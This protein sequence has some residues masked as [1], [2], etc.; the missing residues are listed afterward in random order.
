MVNKNNS[1]S[2]YWANYILR[3]GRR[4]FFICSIHWCSQNQKQNQPGFGAETRTILDICSIK[5]L[6]GRNSVFKTWW[7]LRGGLQDGLWEWCQAH[8]RTGLPGQLQLYGSC[9]QY[10][11]SSALI[12]IS[13]HLYLPTQN[14]QSS[15]KIASATFMLSK[16]QRSVLNLEWVI[17]SSIQ[18]FSCKEEKLFF[19]F[20]A[21]S[22]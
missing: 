19:S 13:L 11:Q 18:N 17:F 12:R 14:S 10:P 9:L 8:S 1:I 15:W 7:G 4:V 20:L 21:F 22:V 3:T 5:E 16:S 2:Y 6:N